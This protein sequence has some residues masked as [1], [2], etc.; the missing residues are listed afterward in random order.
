MVKQ[1]ETMLTVK[2][3]AER[4][5]VTVRT[6]RSWLAVGKIPNVKR[7]STLRGDVLLIPESSLDAVQ[8]EKPGVKPKTEAKPKKASKHKA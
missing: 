4:K 5:G 8:K 6:M 7:E 1:N 2:E 3:F